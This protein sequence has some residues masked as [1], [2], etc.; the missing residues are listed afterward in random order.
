VIDLLN[1]T[2]ILFSNYFHKFHARGGWICSKCHLILL[3]L[4]AFF[5]VEFHMTLNSLNA[6]NANS[7]VDLI[8]RSLQDYILCFVKA[9]KIW[10]KLPNRYFVCITSSN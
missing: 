6:K 5:K 10:G 7:G 9:L 3:C 2:F 4:I 8:I 1:D